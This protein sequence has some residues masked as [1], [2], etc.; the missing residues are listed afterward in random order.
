MRQNKTDL[1]YL[2]VLPIFFRYNHPAGRRKRE[3]QTFLFKLIQLIR[4]V[5]DVLRKK[6]SPSDKEFKSQTFIHLER[7]VI[8]ILHSTLDV[9]KVFRRGL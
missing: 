9:V 8:H 6:E 4:S 2:F 3:H 7:R 5:L 1:S